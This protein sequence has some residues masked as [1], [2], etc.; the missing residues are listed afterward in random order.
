MHTES[1]AQIVYKT[2]SLPPVSPGNSS[3]LRPPLSM[4]LTYTTIGIIMALT[5]GAY[6]L[7][8]LGSRPKDYPPGPPTLPIVGNLHQV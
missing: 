6:Y 7:S 8:G 4:S 2:R 1:F 3:P 5:L